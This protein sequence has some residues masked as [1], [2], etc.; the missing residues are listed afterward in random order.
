MRA[1]STV[2]GEGWSLINN[3]INN[4]N[5]NA[6]LTICISIFQ[7]VLDL[8]VESYNKYGRKCHSLHTTLIWLHHFFPH[9]LHTQYNL[10][11]SIPSLIQLCSPANI[12]NTTFKKYPLKQEANLIVLNKIF[13]YNLFQCCT[14]ITHL[15]VI[16]HFFW[17]NI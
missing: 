12:T 13:F 8:A 15:N 7:Q 3:N 16:N 6:I 17:L 1:D 4:I 11:T 9:N 5:K 2:A 10:S 14:D